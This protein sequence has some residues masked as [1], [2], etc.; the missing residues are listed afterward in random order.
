MQPP[1]MS[2]FISERVWLLSH[3][4]VFSVLTQL[5]FASVLHF[6]TMQQSMVYTVVKVLRTGEGPKKVFLFF[7][8]LIV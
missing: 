1:L 4:N 6:S 8:P 3:L 2:G 7:F 5:V